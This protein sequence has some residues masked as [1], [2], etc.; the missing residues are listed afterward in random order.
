VSDDIHIDVFERIANIATQ[1]HEMSIDRVHRYMT[2]SL[3]TSTGGWDGASSS[4]GDMYHEA[5]IPS[6]VEDI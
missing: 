5:D 2:Q 1:V 3:S 6:L 4:P